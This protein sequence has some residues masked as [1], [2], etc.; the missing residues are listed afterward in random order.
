MGEQCKL[1]RRQEREGLLV[2]QSVRKE[3]LN[4]RIEDL[5]VLVYDLG[6]GTFDVTLLSINQSG[7]RTL[8][9]DGDVRHQ[10]ASGRTVCHVSVL[11][12]EAVCLCLS[13][14]L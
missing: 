1:A 8:A 12:R 3:T 10:Q 5:K 4:T 9:T 2:A 11:H 7:F 13:A 6:G 14:Q